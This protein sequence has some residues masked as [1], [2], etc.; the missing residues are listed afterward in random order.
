MMESL[1]WPGSGGEGKPV[2]LC[3]GRE[4]RASHLGAFIQPLIAAGF[5]VIAYD[6]P[7]HGDSPG[8]T[9]SVVSFG[10]AL[11]SVANEIGPPEGLVSHSLGSYRGHPL[12]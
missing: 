11:I 10:R 7:A 2:L 6:A 4:S 1:S 5:S 8:G 3:H 9:A 12:S